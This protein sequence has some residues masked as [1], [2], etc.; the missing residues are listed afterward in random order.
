MKF[1]LSLLPSCGTNYH[2]AVILEITIADSRSPSLPPARL[3]AF[4]VNFIL[5]FKEVI[6]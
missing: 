6:H 3:P 1:I 5:V 2:A 4:K